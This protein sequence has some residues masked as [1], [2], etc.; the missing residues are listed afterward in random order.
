M[1]TPTRISEPCQ[2]WPEESAFIREVL[3][4][5]GDKWTMLIISTLGGGVLRYSE[6]QASIPGISQRMLTQTL[7]NL[8]RDGLIT[9]TAHAEVPPRVEYELTDLGRSLM[10][11]VMAMA[12]WAATH[13]SEIAS[14]RAAS[15]R[16]GVGRGKAPVRASES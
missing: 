6:L 16:T 12:G 11:A 2:A 9:R 14:N 8:E 13:H 1:V 15:E 5:I 10:N 4:R 3:D 7:K